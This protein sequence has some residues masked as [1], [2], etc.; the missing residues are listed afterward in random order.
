MFK[1]T[2]HEDFGLIPLV[3]IKASIVNSINYIGYNYRIKNG[4][5]YE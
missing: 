5:Y 1:R 4:N 3:I 2:I